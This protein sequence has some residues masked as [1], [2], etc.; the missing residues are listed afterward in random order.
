MGPR[1]DVRLDDA[2]MT[3]VTCT[4][5]GAHVQARKSSWEQTTVQWSTRA[6]ATCVERR[7]TA[8]RTGPNGTTFLGC[9]ALSQSLRE[10][11][12]A[13]DLPVLDTEPGREREDAS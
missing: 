13:G 6:V 9:S 5:C 2:P 4:T 11:A 7:D 3:A 12:V 10:S 8:T 1:P